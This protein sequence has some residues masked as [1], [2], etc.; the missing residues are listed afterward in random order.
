MMAEVFK[1][2]RLSVSGSLPPNKGHVTCPITERIRPVFRTFTRGFLA[3]FRG[4]QP[5]DLGSKTP[6]WLLT[7]NLIDF[8]MLAVNL[9]W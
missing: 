3:F 5:A 1:I 6:E 9:E 2:L 8:L 4:F 7:E